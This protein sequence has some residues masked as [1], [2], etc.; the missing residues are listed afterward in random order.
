[1]DSKKAIE[2]INHVSWQE[3]RLGL[4]RVQELLRRLGNPQ[5]KLRFVHVAGTNGKGSFCAMTARIL[6]AAG[7]RTGLY[8]SPFIRVFNERIQVDSRH[9]SDKDIALLTQE[10]ALHADA[11]EDHP[12]EF[13]MVTVLAFLYFARKACDIVVLEVGLGGRLDATNVINTPELAVITTIS[14]DHVNELGD[15]PEK[16][17]AEKAGI[18]KTGGDVLLYPQSPSVQR[19][20]EEACAQN[21]AQL[22]TLNLSTLR[23]GES[24]ITGQFFSYGPVK[25]IKIPLLGAYQAQNAALC[26]RAVELLRTK[27]WHIS[28]VALHRGLESVSWPARFE[29]VCTEPVFIVDGGHNVQCVKALIDN[30]NCYFPRKKF[31][32]VVGTM[33]DKDYNSMFKLAAPLAKQVFCV[34]PENPRALPAEQLAQ[35]IQQLGVQNVSSCE[36]VIQGVQAALDAASEEDIL[37]AFGSFYMAGEIRAHFG[38]L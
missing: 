31:I 22:Y 30:L 14:L 5:E 34:T 24:G 10:I 16:I 25:N 1:M 37:C 12:T 38:K 13:E 11:M 28:E 7:Y 21:G 9:I 17:A 20:I 6:S 8:T 27:G 32:F 26:L 36:S 18:I 4:H 15:T 35:T 3:S 19:V 23:R 29:L 33:A 2:Y